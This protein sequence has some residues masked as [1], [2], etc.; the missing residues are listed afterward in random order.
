MDFFLFFEGITSQNKHHANQQI[1]QWRCDRGGTRPV[2]SP[3]SCSPLWGRAKTAGGHETGFTELDFDLAVST[4]SNHDKGGDVELSVLGVDLK[5][6]KDKD[7]G[8]STVSRLKFSVQFSIP[9]EQFKKELG[10]NASK[11]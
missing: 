5:L 3:K 4:R 2:A 10:A 6:G 7:T 11:N 8:H 9:Q 1:N